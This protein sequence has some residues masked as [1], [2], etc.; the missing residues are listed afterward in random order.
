MI[1]EMRTYKTTRMR[2]RFIEI[3]HS[4]TIPAHREI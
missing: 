2:S 1:I 4:K 3:F